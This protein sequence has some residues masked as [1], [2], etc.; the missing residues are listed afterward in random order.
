MMRLWP[1]GIEMEKESMTS[2][3]LVRVINV[4]VHLSRQWEK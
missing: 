4:A 3:F 2:Q 1:N